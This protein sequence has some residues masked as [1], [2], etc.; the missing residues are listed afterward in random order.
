[1]EMMRRNNSNSNQKSATER[2]AL[3][4]STLLIVGLF[5]LSAFAYAETAEELQQKIGE[6]NDAINQLENEIKTYQ[7]ELDSIGKDTQ[8][9]QG[10]INALDI[11]RRKLLAELKVT[12]EKIKNVEKKIGT[13]S[14]EITTKDGELSGNRDAL[15]NSIRHIDILEDKSLL[16]LMLEKG[17]MNDTWQDIDSLRTLNKGIKD[18]S[19]TVRGI[20]QVLVVSKTEQEKARAELLSL[21]SELSDQKKIIDQNTRDKAELLAET[22]NKESNYKKILSDKVALKSAYEREVQDYESHLQYILNPN[23]L[24]KIGSSPLYWPLDNPYITQLFGRTSS[25]GRLYASGSHSGVD[26]RA[27]VGTPVF[28]MAS[29]TVLGTGDTDST[30]RGASFG[31]WVYVKFDNGLG[32]TYGHL[33]LIKA[34]SGERVGVGDLLAYSGQSGHV[35]GPHLHI[36]VYDASAVR[37]EAKPSISCRGRVLTQPLAPTAAYLDPILYLPRATASMMKYGAGAVSSLD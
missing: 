32:A 28:A 21:K 24:P 25:S 23:L 36:S 31:K 12:G 33:S 22:K 29:G 2:S 20:R 26:F 5:G 19:D 34:Y 27:S 17:S 14:S 16:V 9:L 4:L 1:M 10:A 13:L 30:C 6:K 7:T 15:A 8:T 11:S 35:T 37:I 18:H 3:F